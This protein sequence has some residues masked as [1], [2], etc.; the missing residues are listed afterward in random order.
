MIQIELT[1]P[2]VTEARNLIN[3]VIL[4]NIPVQMRD[5]PPGISAM[6]RAVTAS[7]E[8]NDADK[9]RY[10]TLLRVLSKLRAS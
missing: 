2:E 3:S 8:L 9:K 6:R 1:T 7:D 10:N 4:D 5:C